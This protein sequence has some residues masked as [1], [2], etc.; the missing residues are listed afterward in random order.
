MFAYLVHL[1]NGQS[2]RVITA[3][4][5]TNHPTFWG[6]VASVEKVETAPFA[7]PMSEGHGR[8]NP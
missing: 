4:D 2:V 7:S 5:P 8:I 6:R 1:T 3:G